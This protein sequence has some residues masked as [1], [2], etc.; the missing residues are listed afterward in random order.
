MSS[1]QAEQNLLRPMRGEILIIQPLE[2]IKVACG[3][4]SPFI[5]YYDY[6]SYEGISECCISSSIK[7]RQSSECKSQK[8]Y[9]NLE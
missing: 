8:C 9:E 5:V 4:Y 7:N 6:E 1:L 3:A 2:V